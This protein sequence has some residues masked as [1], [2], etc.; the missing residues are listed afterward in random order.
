LQAVAR[1]AAIG[2]QQL[3]GQHVAVEGAQLGA[4]LGCE[5]LQQHGL[6]DQVCGLDAGAGAN[7]A[8]AMSSVVQLGRVNQPL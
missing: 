3:E 1:V 6:A 8:S 4:A 5:Q 7:E 2:A